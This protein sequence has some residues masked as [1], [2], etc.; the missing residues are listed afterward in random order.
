MGANR[1]DPVRGRPTEAVATTLPIN[2]AQPDN[3]NQRNNAPSAF[4]TAPAAS[5]AVRLPADEFGNIQ[6][7]LSQVANT[8]GAAPNPAPALN[9]P[10]RR[11]N[12]G[13]A[14]PPAA[15]TPQQDEVRRTPSATTAK[16][17]VDPYQSAEDEK[18]Q[19]FVKARERAAKVQGVAATPVNLLTISQFV[20]ETHLFLRLV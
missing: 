2:R 14:N 10:G 19:L 20:W 11:S 8:T 15:P 3:A 17:V 1:A 16:P 4:H 7:T 18:V 13:G 6:R 9:T 12:S 5:P